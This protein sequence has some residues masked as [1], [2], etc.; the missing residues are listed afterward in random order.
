MTDFL[1]MTT[2]SERRRCSMLC[3]FI[4]MLCDSCPCVV[5]SQ[6]LASA[7]ASWV[8]LSQW[9]T[10]WLTLWG[11]ELWASTETRSTTSCPPVKILLCPIFSHHEWVDVTVFPWRLLLFT[12][13]QTS[14]SYKYDS[15][16]WC[17]FSF[18]FDCP[19]IDNMISHPD[20]IM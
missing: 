2:I 4:H 13:K 9:W 5:L 11:R 16:W 3:L 7:L 8:E 20:F 17:T 19:N 14:K 6:C 18:H 12:Q 10:F 15:Y 1:I